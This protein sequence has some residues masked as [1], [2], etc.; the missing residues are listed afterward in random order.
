[1]EA[2]VALLEMVREHLAARLAALTKAL[3]DS[4]AAATDPDSKAEGKYDTR[5]LEMSYLANGQEKQAVA[6]R[7][8]L[9]IL[10]DFEP[11]N[12]DVMS[13]IAIG[14]LVELTRAGEWEHYLL[15]PT[16]GGILLTFEGIDVTTVSP[17]SP[18]FSRLDGLALG[19]E[20]DQE[21][22]ITEV[23]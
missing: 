3:V 23:S 17:E 20:I 19:D 18:I 22:T 1:M 2:K 14:A 7:K 6:L 16:A 11:R 8:S 12:F 10:E 5:S 4:T 13:P 21:L 15:L 9:E